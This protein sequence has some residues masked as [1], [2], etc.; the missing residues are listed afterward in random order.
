MSRGE[1]TR[2]REYWMSVTDML[3]YGESYSQIVDW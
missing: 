1:T 2:L 3:D